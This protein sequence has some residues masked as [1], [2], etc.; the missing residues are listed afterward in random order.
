MSLILAMLRGINVSGQKKVPMVELKAMFEEMKFKNVTTYIQSGN[1]VFDA[2]K[3]DPAALKSKLENKIQKT[4]GFDVSVILRT[5]E[6][7]KNA[8]QSCGYAKEQNI[9][10]SRVY[11]A[12]LEEAP[13]KENLAKLK[14][15]DF[16]PDR[17]E[18]KGKEVYMHCPVSYGNSKLNNN[19]FESKLKVVATTRNWKSVNELFKLLQK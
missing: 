11:V 6:E 18:V 15:F 2:G 9:D 17:F 1:V 8:I 5:A 14:T 7:M 13:A 12:F 3:A 16:P 4:F 10:M 19:F